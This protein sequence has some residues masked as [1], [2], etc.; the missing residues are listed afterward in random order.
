ML[1]PAV[2]V[3]QKEATKHT[4][5]ILFFN[6]PSDAPQTLYL[7]D[8]EEAQE[9]ELPKMN[10]SPVYELRAGAVKLHLLP[11]PPPDPANIPA[12]APYAKV[13]EGVVDYYLLVTSDPANSVAPVRLQVIDAGFDK[14]K[15][16]QMLWFNLTPNTIGGDVGTQRL[17]IQPNSREVLDAPASAAG[18]YPIQLFF[19]IPGDNHTYPLCSTSWGHDPRSRNIIFINMEPDSR[20]PRV[21][22]YSDYRQ[23]SSKKSP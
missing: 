23:P 15:A 7:F 6:A 19:Q 14:L 1:F 16:G 8:G 17:I 13:S 3:A 18:E 21:A 22:G 4:C 2:A 9:V 20:T 12:N 11:A 5:R 10:F